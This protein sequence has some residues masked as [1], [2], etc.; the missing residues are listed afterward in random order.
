MLDK[1]FL[2]SSERSSF[3]ARYGFSKWT[4]GLLDKRVLPN[5]ERFSLPAHYGSSSWTNGLLDNFVLPN[6]D[7]LVLQPAMGPAVGQMACWTSLFFPVGERF[8]PPAH[9]GSSSWTNGLLD[10]L[11]RPN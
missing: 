7:S 10:E 6:S 8:S 2:L 5:W 3:P 4:N 11:V 9:H 1:L